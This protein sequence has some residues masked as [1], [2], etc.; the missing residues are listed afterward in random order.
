MLKFIA[1]PGINFLDERDTTPIIKRH[2]KTYNCRI[3]LENRD[4]EHFIAIL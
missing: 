3:K 4:G 1:K 2:I